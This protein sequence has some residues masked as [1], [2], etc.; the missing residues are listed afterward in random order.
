MKDGSKISGIMASKTETEIDLKFPGGNKQSIKTSD[1][2]SI[3][4]IKGIYDARRI[5]PGNDSARIGRFA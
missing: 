5:A 4:E 3:E 2:K 1:V